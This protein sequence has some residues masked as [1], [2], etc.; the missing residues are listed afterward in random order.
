VQLKRF[1]PQ[2]KCGDLEFGKEQ[3]E[4][5]LRISTMAAIEA[6]CTNIGFKKT[7]DNYF[8]RELTVDTLGLLAFNFVK[9]GNMF[10]VPSVAVG[11]QP[12]QRLIAEVKGEKFNPYFSGTLASQL[13][14]VPPLN[15][16]LWF[17]FPTDI[18]PKQRV[19]ELFTVIK[20]VAVPWMERHRSLE[21]FIEDL[22]DYSFVDRDQMRM[23]RPA[24]YYL[25]NQHD[26]ARCPSPKSHRYS[27]TKVTVK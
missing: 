10:V 23:R 12:L 18:D 13:G 21:S 17:E 26:L 14:S 20:D 15:E 16:L 27:E 9:D 8:T 5:N 19:R 24:A 25:N 2:L 7:D 3:M 22:K 4:K 1:D 11:H 6:E